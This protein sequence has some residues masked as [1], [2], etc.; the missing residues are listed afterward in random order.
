MGNNLSLSN[1]HNVQGK[2]FV[3]TNFC[4]YANTITS[5]LIPHHIICKPLH[6]AAWQSSSCSGVQSFESRVW[7]PTW[8]GDQKQPYSNPLILWNTLDDLASACESAKTRIFR[9]EMYTHTSFSPPPSSFKSYCIT[10]LHLPLVSA[11]CKNLKLQKNIFPHTQKKC[12][13]GYT[14]ITRSRVN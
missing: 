14:D 2:T 11:K 5:S 10:G 3:P 12:L 6:F 4:H 13:Q 1:K 8:Q 7:L 9:W